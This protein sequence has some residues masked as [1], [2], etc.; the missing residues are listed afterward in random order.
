MTRM[1]TLSAQ[2]TTWHITWG[3]YGS[4]LHGSDK[5][6]VDRKR[7]IRGQP[8]VE[9]NDHR[10]RFESNIATTQAVY[11]T[12]DH[13]CHIESAIPEICKRGGWVYRIAAAGPEC[14][15]VHVL[16]DIDPKTHGKDARKWMKRWLSES[17]NHHWPRVDGRRWW[18]QGGSTRPVKEE[19][20]LN[21]VYEY[22]K[23]QRATT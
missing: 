16:C 14:D 1:Q 6:T 23:T 4:R 10:E 15:H 11:L 18:A 20:Y 12:L 8:F 17:L 7:N 2:M 21:N 3:T 22:L 9:R 5:P 13:R 19:R